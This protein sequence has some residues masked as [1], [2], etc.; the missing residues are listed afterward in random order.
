MHWRAV[1]TASAV[2]V[3]VID[4]TTTGAPPPTWTRPTL[5]PMVL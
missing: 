4:W 2:S 3:M 1:D 5:T